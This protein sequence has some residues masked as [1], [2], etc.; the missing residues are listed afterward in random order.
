MATIKRFESRIEEYEDV[1]NN[2]EV[3]IKAITAA[4]YFARA[5]DALQVEFEPDV[6][7]GNA[8]DIYY[9]LVRDYLLEAADDIE[10]FTDDDDFTG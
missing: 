5:L 8:H 2:P 3:Y 6:N 4:R 10:V 7:D 1:A 9:T